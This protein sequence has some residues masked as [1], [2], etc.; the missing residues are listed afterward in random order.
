MSIHHR[1]KGVVTADV[2]MCSSQ[3]REEEIAVRQACSTNTNRKQSQIRRGVT[4]KCFKIGATLK[5]HHGEWTRGVQFSKWHRTFKIYEI[6]IVLSKAVEIICQNSSF[7]WHSP[8]N[9]FHGLHWL[10]EGWQPK[11]LKC[12]NDPAG[13]SLKIN[14]RTS[15]F[16]MMSADPEKLLKCLTLYTTHNQDLKWGPTAA[17]SCCEITQSMPLVV[18]CLI[19]NC[20]DVINWHKDGK[21]S[22]EYRPLY[23]S[24]PRTEGSQWSRSRW[25]EEHGGAC[26]TDCGCMWSKVRSQAAVR[27]YVC[28]GS[29]GTL[30]GFFWRFRRTVIDP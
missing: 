22:H 14:L 8:S 16:D 23:C 17:L 24:G 25:V 15:C 4:F 5:Y 18:Y 30:L 6:L 1:T 10:F 13:R 19:Q 11:S 27:C 21:R 29:G 26:I 20:I 3:R 12:Q 2:N 7:R 28:G 9:A